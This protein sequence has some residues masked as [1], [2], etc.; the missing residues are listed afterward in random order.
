MINL[1]GK[2]QQKIRVKKKNN[3]KIQIKNKII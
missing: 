1:K 2:T 3:I